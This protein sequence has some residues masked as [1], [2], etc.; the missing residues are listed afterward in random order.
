MRTIRKKSSPI[1]GLAVAIVVIVVMAV[2]MLSDIELGSNNDS[3]LKITEIH[4]MESDYEGNARFYVSI[5][6][7]GGQSS[8]YPS[9]SLEGEYGDYYTMYLSQEMQPEEYFN[10]IEIP[11]GEETWGIYVLDEYSYSDLIDQSCTVTL[12]DVYDD[13]ANIEIYIE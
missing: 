1:A 4:Q 10:I 13:S 6:N 12:N 9:I 3:K 2:M 8:S 7:D 11:G 5:Q